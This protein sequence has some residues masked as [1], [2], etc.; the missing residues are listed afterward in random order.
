MKL[1]TKIL[2]ILGGGVLLT[3]PII[4]LSSCSDDGSANK[5][6]QEYLAP[7]KIIGGIKAFEGTTIKP[8]NL[9]NSIIEYNGLNVIATTSSIDNKFVKLELPLT[10]GEN[11]FEGFKGFDKN[12]KIT[13]TSKTKN[14]SVENNFVFN[15]TELTNDTSNII[16]SGQLLSNEKSF[17]FDLNISLNLFAQSGNLT[18]DLFEFTT[19]ESNKTANITKYVG[20]NSEVQLPSIIEY[21]GISYTVS[22]IN[23]DIFRDKSNDISRVIMDASLPNLN[24]G[25]MFSSLPNLVYVKLSNNQL[26]TNNMFENTTKLKNVDFNSSIQTSIPISCFLNSG[27]ENLDLSSSKVTIF[28]Q[29]SFKNSKISNIILPTTL[30]T[31]GGSAFYSC[32][33]LI[34]IDLT[35]I[36]CDAEFLIDRLAFSNCINLENI[37][38]PTE[39]NK[40][41]ILRLKEKSLEETKTIELNAK[42]IN[43]LILDGASIFKRAIVSTNMKNI[44][45]PNEFSATTNEWTWFTSGHDKLVLS[46]INEMTVQQVKEKLLLSDNTWN[47]YFLLKVSGEKTEVSS[48]NNINSSLLGLNGI[49]G[50]NISNINQNFLFNNKEKLLN[51][52]L[53]LIRS[54]NDFTNL[55]VTLLENTKLNVSFD[56]VANATYNSDGSVNGNPKNIN[57]VIDG[58]QE[59]NQDSFVSTLRDEF[60]KFLTPKTFA[61]PK[62]QAINL[63]NSTIDEA[64]Y[65]KAIKGYLGKNDNISKIGGNYDSFWRSTGWQN[66]EAD[67]NDMKNWF[68]NEVN[69]ETYLKIESL[70]KQWGVINN[71]WVVSKFYIYYSVESV[72]NNITE[73]SISKFKIIPKGYGFRINNS[74]GKEVTTLL[75]NITI[76]PKGDPI[77]NSINMSVN[78]VI[79]IKNTSSGEIGSLVSI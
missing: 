15:E 29:N 66:N 69:S 52:T 45:L 59:I 3:T 24:Y 4:T 32:Q 30:R 22:N 2:T 18:N 20:N 53:S 28:E 13:W 33:N 40:I 1:K 70:L 31:I 14:F 9:N 26:F 25:N 48:K 12:S 41:N 34:N 16:V 72:E 8:I 17:N 43:N 6:T 60:S 38:L 56:I 54:E 58:F 67:I 77:A 51:G 78:K 44:Y 21:E 19:N 55:N 37:N 42:F 61:T 65:F 68:E 39:K 36:I 35:N 46:L 49:A 23:S 47:S 74:T 76:P 79:Q 73:N 75:N 57:L 27:I 10:I 63:G 71:D 50:V 62:N 5:P 11:Q 7:N 64:S